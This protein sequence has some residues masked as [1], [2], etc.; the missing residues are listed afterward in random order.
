MS[1]GVPTACKE[2]LGSFI[3]LKQQDDHEDAKRATIG[4][5]EDLYLQIKFLKITNIFGWSSFFGR[6]PNLKWYAVDHGKGIVRLMMG[7]KEAFV[8]ECEPS[9][10]RLAEGD[11]EVASG[12]DAVLAVALPARR[13]PPGIPLSSIEQLLR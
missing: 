11:L 1:K 3:S 9:C 10:A 7:D 6:H 5:D 13:R 8:S 12:L 4:S 2:P